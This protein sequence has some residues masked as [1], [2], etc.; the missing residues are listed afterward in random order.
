MK[1]MSYMHWDKIKCN[2]SATLTFDTYETQTLH[3]VQIFHSYNLMSDGS[4]Q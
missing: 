1:K 2:K 3:L 4:S